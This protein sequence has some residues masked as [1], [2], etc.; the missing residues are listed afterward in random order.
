MTMTVLSRA[1]SGDPEIGNFKNPITVNFL[2]FLLKKFGSS[3]TYQ[4][5]DGQNVAQP[6]EIPGHKMVHLIKG[7]A[8][9]IHKGGRNVLIVDS[10]SHKKPSLFA[11]KTIVQ[12]YGEKQ[13]ASLTVKGRK[14]GSIRISDKDLAAI[15]EFVVEYTKPKKFSWED[16]LQ[17]L[18]KK[19]SAAKSPKSS[20]ADEEDK[21]TPSKMNTPKKGQPTKDEERVIASPSKFQRG[22]T[23]TELPSSSS[24]SGL[25]VQLHYSLNIYLIL[26]V[27][28]IEDKHV[29]RRQ[30]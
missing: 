23:V 21:I 7:H 14:K 5:S 9:K 8:L 19:I 1:M 12:L 18:T 16:F 25:E 3:P 15:Y 22:L 13:L 30:V 29:A 17:S 24:S 26:T 4:V 10:K 28:T 6:Q 27:L 2:H 11:R 20:K